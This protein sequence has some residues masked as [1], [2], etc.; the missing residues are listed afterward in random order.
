MSSLLDK[1]IQFSK[2]ASAA[3]M[4][5]NYPEALRLYALTL[6]SWMAAVRTGAIPEGSAMVVRS[7]MEQ[8]KERYAALKEMLDSKKKQPVAA[9]GKKKSSGKKKDKG[10]SG[11]DG[12]EE[13]EE[14][15]EEE[16]KLQDAIAKVMVS[17]SPN[18]KWDD[19][20][21]LEAAKGALREAVILPVKFPQFFTGKRSPWRAILL[22]GPPGT[23]KSYLAKA[24]ATEIDSNFFSVSSS[25]L[26]SK[27][28]G[29][30]ERLVKAMF[31]IAR[32]KAPSIIFVDEID[33]LCGARGDNE[34]ESSRRIKNE[35]LIQMQGVG[36][37][38]KGVLVLGATNFPWGLDSAIRRRF[39]KRI[40]IGLPEAPART[41]MFKIHLGKTPNELTEGD[42]GKLGEFSKGFSGSDIGTL[43][44]DALMAPIRDFQKATKFYPKEVDVPIKN[45][46]GEVISSKRETKWFP[47]TDDMTGDPPGTVARDPF[48]FNGEDVGDMPVKATHFM[49]ALSKIHASVGEEDLKKQE[50]FRSKYGSE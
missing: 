21:G 30:S 37:D 35:F 4:A 25:D 24:V 42:F 48:S 18:V 13:E 27:W 46:D 33:A 26:V 2:Q 44:R 17:E 5:G 49:S 15:D 6:R 16:R 38:N 39:E 43:V 32:K 8:Y 34:S 9:G 36:R 45:D 19:V 41:A 7:K 28:Q 3:D 47:I 14:M 40:Y 29:E 10:K 22:Y 20:A 11:E 12:E 31:E 23:G 50:D 1:T